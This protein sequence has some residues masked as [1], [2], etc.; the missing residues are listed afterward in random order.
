MYCDQCGVSAPHEVGIGHRGVRDDRT[1]EA[2]GRKEL[3]EEHAPRPTTVVTLCPCMPKTLGDCY[4]CKLWEAEARLKLFRKAQL[5]KRILSGRLAN[6]REAQTRAK[7]LHI[8]VGKLRTSVDESKSMLPEYLKNKLKEVAGLTATH[9]GEAGKALKKLQEA[10]SPLVAARPI[11]DAI[12]ALLVPCTATKY[13]IKSTNCGAYVQTAV[14]ATVEAVCERLTDSGLS[15]DQAVARIERVYAAAKK[16]DQEEFRAA[17]DELGIVASDAPRASTRLCCGNERCMKQMWIRACPVVRGRGASDGS[18]GSA[19][20]KTFWD[21]SLKLLALPAMAMRAAGN[22]R[23]ATEERLVVLLKDEFW[24]LDFFNERTSQCASTLFALRFNPFEHDGNL[25]L[26]KQASA[27]A[28]AMAMGFW[29]FTFAPVLQQVVGCVWAAERACDGAVQAL[30][31]VSDAARVFLQD[32]S[33]KGSGVVDG[34]LLATAAT[35]RAAPLGCFSFGGKWLPSFRAS[36]VHHNLEDA[37]RSTTSKLCQ[38]NEMG[39][40]GQSKDNGMARALVHV[41]ESFDETI[42]KVKRGDLPP[43]SSSVD[44]VL[45]RAKNLNVTQQRIEAAARRIEAVLPD[46]WGG[47]FCGLDLAAAKEAFPDRHPAVSLFLPYPTDPRCGADGHYLKVTIASTSAAQAPQD[48]RGRVIGRGAPAEMRPIGTARAAAPPKARADDF[49]ALE[50]LYI[51]LVHGERL[52]DEHRAK[53]EAFTNS[54]EKAKREAGKRYWRVALHS[55]GLLKFLLRNP[56]AKTLF[57]ETF[58]PN[59]ENLEELFPQVVQAVVDLHTKSTTFDK[60]E[61]LLL[62]PQ[63][64]DFFVAAAAT[65]NCTKS[66]NDAAKA[67]GKC[68]FDFAVIVTREEQR[69]MQQADANAAY[70]AAMGDDGPNTS[71][72]RPRSI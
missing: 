13:T 65:K 10:L 68:D 56:D 24:R 34:V 21:V 38:L 1:E 60:V 4:W 18:T 22:E 50:K 64:V 33:E 36:N 72:K 35:Y 71:P 55:K 14:E 54:V 20:A 43:G 15:K 48:P 62:M 57:K 26:A 6:L 40:G 66:E 59:S 25:E 27:W 63:I 31:C 52:D 69:R 41:K 61:D 28:M 42:E 49:E 44:H 46:F 30:K 39:R 19:S 29:S 2:I 3:A 37:V 47:V 7:D 67:I 53:R 12:D 45:P 8:E 9:K 51:Q 11:G 58:P 17:L 5:M 32:E 16:C 70:L 23:Q